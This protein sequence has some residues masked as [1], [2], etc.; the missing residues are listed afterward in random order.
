MERGLHQRVMR[1]AKDRRLG[2]RHPAHQ[3]L[4]MA[5]H[6]CLGED[7]VALLDGIDHAAAGLRL[8]ID[9]DGAE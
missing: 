6:Q 7:F 4:D 5:A 3:R 8:D 9:A 1:A 2:V